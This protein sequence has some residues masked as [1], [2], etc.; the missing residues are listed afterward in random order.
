MQ[1]FISDGIQIF[2]IGIDRQDFFRV[3]GF[4]KLRVRVLFFRQFI[5]GFQQV[6]LNGFEGF[7]R[8]VVGV[9]VGVAFIVFRQVVSEVDYINIQRTTIYR[10]T[11]GGRDRVILIIQQRVKCTNRQNCQFFQFIQV[12]NCVQVESRQRIQRD[13]IVFVVDVVQRF[14]RQGYFQVQVR[15]TY[16]RDGRIKRVMG[17]V[18]V[19]V[20]NIDTIGR[21][22]FL[23]YQ[24]EQFNGFYTLFADVVV[25]F[26][27]GIQTFKFFLI[28]EERV[29]QFRYVGRVEQGDI[30]IFQQTGIYQ[31]VDLYFVVY[32]TYAV[33]FYITVVF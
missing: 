8:Q 7:M 21:R 6:I 4:V 1:R 14:G 20:L 15:L 19:N 5:R 11:F 16:W 3:S 27:F 25:F 2:F 22:T 29:V 26:I 10:F 13:F 18:V 28:G 23:Y 9:V 33:V 32:M 17:I 31:F 30:F 24:R 12:I